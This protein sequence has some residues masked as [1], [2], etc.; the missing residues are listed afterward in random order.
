MKPWRGGALT[1]MGDRHNFSDPG[2][3]RVVRGAW[4]QQ[5]APAGMQFRVSSALATEAAAITQSAAPGL[6]RVVAGKIMLLKNV[7]AAAVLLIGL[8]TLAYQSGWI[9]IRLPSKPTPYVATLLDRMVRTHAQ[10]LHPVVIA[11]SDTTEGCGGMTSVEA[12]LTNELGIHVLVPQA[13]EGW[14]FVGAER[15]LLAD[16]PAARAFYER[17]GRTLSVFSIL[18]PSGYGPAD[19]TVYE[20]VRN[21]RAIVGVVRGPSLYCVVLGDTSG[22]ASLREARKLRD[23]L[24]G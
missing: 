15:A 9:T 21:G 11:A 19:G 10:E 6:G 13:P 7:A 4:G 2:L 16:T 1:M 12:E 3:K 22:Q 18:T 5:G 24:A 23:Q 14:K 17:D 8:A 20:E